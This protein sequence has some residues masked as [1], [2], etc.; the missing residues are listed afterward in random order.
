MGCGSTLESIGI[1]LA[2][3]VGSAFLGPEVGLGLEGL[4]G[5]AFT[6]AETIGGALA[7]A[8]LGAAGSAITGGNPLIG[9]LTGGAGGAI[10]PNISDIVGGITGSPSTAASGASG[11]VSAAPGAAPG[12]AAAAAPA[13]V[14]AAGGGDVGFDTSNLFTGP[15]S[16]GSGGGS[17]LPSVLGGSGG[18]PSAAD[19]SF[20]AGSPTG[21]P[22]VGQGPT[23]ANAAGAGSAEAPNSIST[24]WSDPSTSNILSALGKNSNVLVPGAGLAFNAIQGNQA[25]KGLSNIEQQAGQLANQGGQLQSYLQTGTLPPGVQ[26][27]ID[28]ASQSAK[29]AIRSQYASMGLSGSSAEQQALANVDTTSASQGASLAL[30]LLNEGVNET[31]LS[32]QLY[33]QIMSTTL[34]QDQNLQNAVSNF[35]TA[36]GGGGT[37]LKLAAA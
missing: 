24:A 2:A 1:P 10:G 12:A 16:G 18:T 33:Q 4:A 27:S 8:G 34:Q 11:T 32:S 37:T 14:G 20:L 7:G 9:A 22:N 13:S 35:A 36:A 15:V 28:Q 19:T 31:Q 26:G 21:A 30:N 3:T 29:A 17:S 23:I 25:P 5:G 6:G